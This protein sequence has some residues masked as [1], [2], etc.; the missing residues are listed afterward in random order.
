MSRTVKNSKAWVLGLLGLIFCRI[1]WVDSKDDSWR[2]YVMQRRFLLMLLV[3]PVVLPCYVV[4]HGLAE[5]PL[6]WWH[7]IS[8]YRCHYIRQPG[9]NSETKLSLREKVLYMNIF[10]ADY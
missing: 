2:G 3:S 10:I 6:K 4:W 9:Q 1:V 8:T 7:F 5:G